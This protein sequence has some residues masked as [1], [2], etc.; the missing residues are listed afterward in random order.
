MAEIFLNW[1]ALNGKNGHEIGRK[2]LAE[3]Y[4]AHVGGVMPEILTADG[5]KPCFATGDW[6]FSISHSKNHAFCVLADHPVGIDAE[7][8]DRQIRLSIAP[9]IL[10]AGE[11]AQF[12]AADDP[13]DTLLRFW[14]LK[15]AA[16]KHSGKGIGFHPRHTDFKLPD[17]RI[18]EIDGC[19]VAVV[20]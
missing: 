14:V 1:Q 10:S 11:L 7:E 9:K 2:L 12:D 20:D 5:G 16:A 8:I 4:E 17:S 6:Y 15:E 3:L 13:R 18:A 19:L